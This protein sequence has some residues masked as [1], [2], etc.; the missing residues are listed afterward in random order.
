V[1]CLKCT[2]GCLI[3]VCKANP[4]YE[5][6][7][8]HGSDSEDSCCLEC[9]T[10]QSSSFV[11]YLPYTCKFLNYMYNCVAYSNI[12]TSSCKLRLDF[13]QLLSCYDTVERV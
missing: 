10:V 5:V 11:I 7:D 4:R 9:D 2:Q 3:N 8:S 12:F 1:I 13:Q 6:F